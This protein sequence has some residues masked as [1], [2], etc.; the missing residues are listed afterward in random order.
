[1][2]LSKKRIQ[3]F[4]REAFSY[5]EDLY[6]GYGDSGYLEKFMNTIDDES[7]TFKYFCSGKGIRSMRNLKLPEHPINVVVD[8]EYLNKIADLHIRS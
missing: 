4:V 7:Y 3:N 6:G 5:G 1:M 2:L 8:K